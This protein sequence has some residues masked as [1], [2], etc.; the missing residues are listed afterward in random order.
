MWGKGGEFKLKKKKT[1]KKGKKNQV[2]SLIDPE[3]ADH[4]TFSTPIIQI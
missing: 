1:K 3:V 2:S 4:S